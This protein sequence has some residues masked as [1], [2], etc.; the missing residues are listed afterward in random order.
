MRASGDLT[1]AAP[2]TLKTDKGE[3][4]L[5]AC[6][7]A[8]RHVHMSPEKAESL[9]VKDKQKIG[10]RIGGERSGIIDA[11]VKISDNAYFEAHVDTDDSNAFLLGNDNEGTLIV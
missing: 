5:D 11:F 9:G 8:Q 10:I 4:T 7:L 2:I 3:V 1:G 6:I